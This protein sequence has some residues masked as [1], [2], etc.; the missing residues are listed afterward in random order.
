MPLTADE[1]TAVDLCRKHLATVESYR[2]AP[3]EGNPTRGKCYVASVAL[4]E[5]LGGIKAGYHLNKGIDEN[6]DH[7]WVTSRAGTIL[8][9]TIEQFEILG[10]KPPYKVGKKVGRRNTLKKHLPLLEAM[11][12]ETQM[13]GHKIEEDL[14]R[15]RKPNQDLFGREGM[16]G[17][18]SVGK[19][20]ALSEAQEECLADAWHA[21]VCDWA[22]RPEEF[23]R[24]NFPKGALA[25]YFV[26]ALLFG[27]E[28][29]RTATMAYTPHRFGVAGSAYPFNELFPA[30]VKDRRLVRGIRFVLG[31]EISFA[32]LISSNLPVSG[33]RIPADFPIG[34]AKNLIDDYC[35]RGGKVLDPCHGWGGR[36]VGFMLSRAAS[37]VGI[38]PAPHS[39]CLREMFDDLERYLFEEKTCRLINKPFEDVV[40]TDASYDFALTS[41][42]YYNTEKYNG[43]ESSWRR[44]K[45]L[46]AW[47]DGFYRPLIFGVADALKPG[48]YFALQVTP[49]FKMASIAKEIGEEIGLIYQ[50]EYDTKMRRYNSVTADKAGSTDQ[51]EI[52]AIFRKR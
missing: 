16:L 46:E 43:E 32:K 4:L 6:G 17:R 15:F 24:S 12:S 44:Y 19:D 22:E 27:E 25:V 9:P 52:V 47:I 28:I 51:F 23:I 10:I 21:L 29:P 13:N 3:V 41:P 50:R 35:P 11:R 31:N 5:Y 20:E 2:D 14:D 30:A 1:E 40:L 36:L 49:K 37:Y 7:Y 42:P 39:G 38:D 33:Y 8:D 34:L 45:T 26:R 48:A 18:S